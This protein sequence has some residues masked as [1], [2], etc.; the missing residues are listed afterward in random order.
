ME[1]EERIKE[2]EE[3][4]KAYEQI[5]KTT[6]GLVAAMLKVWGRTSE[7]DAVELPLEVVTSAPRNLRLVTLLDTETKVC[8]MYCKEK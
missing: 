7:E 6:E 1:R 5:A 2:L 8:R 3:M 4:V